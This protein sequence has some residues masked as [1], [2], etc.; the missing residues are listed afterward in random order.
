M[1]NPISPMVSVPRGLRVLVCF[2]LAWCLP[3][4]A[5]AAEDGKLKSWTTAE[6]VGAMPWAK[7]ETKVRK[8]RLEFTAADARG[9]ELHVDGGVGNQV[10][11][12]GVVLGGTDHPGLR[13]APARLWVLRNGVSR[14]A[15]APVRPRLDEIG[16][17]A[18]RSLT[19]HQADADLYRLHAFAVRDAVAFRYA[20]MPLAEAT[21]AAELS[22]AALV[23]LGRRR[24]ES[25]DAWSTE[26][27]GF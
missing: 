18:I 9:D 13:R 6:L 17:A 26:P 11:G 1:N 24:G 12:Y 4:A 14:L 2:L 10:F 21:G 16:A 15:P 25:P 23:E 19:H 7:A 5:N 20:A 27:P 3:P 22:P 8:E